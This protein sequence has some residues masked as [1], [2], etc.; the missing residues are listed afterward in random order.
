[1]QFGK[2]KTMNRV[3]A[4]AVLVVS[5]LV[6]LLTIEPTASFW[7]CGEF[8]LTSYNLEIGHPPGNPFFQLMGRLFSMFAAPEHAAMMVNVMSALCSSFTIFFLYL[9]IVHLGRRVYERNGKALD[10]PRSIAVIGAGA[11][12]SMAYCFSDTFWFSA[13][14]GEVYAMSSLFTALVFWAMLRWEEE[15]DSEYADRW[16][17]LI[18]LLMG[19]SIGVHLLNLLALPAIVFIYYYRK[20][21]PTLKKS[22]AALC[23]SALLVAV[24]LFG[25]IPMVPKVASWFDLLFVNVFGLPYNSGTVVFFLLLFA[26]S[27]FSVYWTYSEGKRVLNLV[28]MS[29]TMILFGFSVFAVVLIRSTADT[30]INENQ[31]DNPFSLSSYLARDQYGSTPLLFG[32]AYD[33][34]YS[35]TRDEYYTKLDGKYA[36]VPGPY[37][38]LYDS[39]A[40]MFFPRMWSSSP[41]HVSFYKYYTGGKGN[42]IA[43]TSNYMPKFSDNMAFFF[44]YQINWM[45]VRYF[46]WNF[47]G[48]QNDVHGPVPG[49]I[50]KGNWE[51][52]IGFIDRARLGDQSE[53]PSYLVDSK[54]KNHYYFL[55]F[56]LGLIG[57]FYQLTYDKR[58]WWVTMLLF[59]LT[60]LAIVL[61]L[62]QS[63][64]Q[65]RERDYAYAGSFY[66]FAIWIGLGV[67]ALYDFISSKAKSHGPA[68]ATA[69]AA[70]CFG[71]PVLMGCENWD[72]HD[73]SGR[74]TVKAMAANYL[75]SCG[76]DAILITYGDNDTFPLWYIQEVEGLR[77]DIR[78]VN[79][80]YL[81]TDWYI[82]QMRNRQNDSDPVK[83]S[84]SRKEYV[85]IVNSYVMIDDRIKEPVLLSEAMEIFRNPQVRVGFADGSYHKFLPFRKFIIPVNKENAIAAGLIREEDA[86]KVP[87]S[88]TLSIPEGKND[89]STQELFFLDFLSTYQWDR[90]VSMI[91]LGGDIN[92][93]WTDY[94]RFDGYVYTFVPVKGQTTN[95]SASNIDV[96]MMYD[97]LMNVYSYCFN[98]PDVNYDYQ[99]LSIFNGVASV[100]NS[101]AQVIA[102]M[103]EN[104]DNVRAMEL[105]DRMEQEFPQSTFPYYTSVIP[106]SNTYSVLSVIRARYA[107]GDDDKALDMARRLFDELYS[108][109]KLVLNS[110][111]DEVASYLLDENLGYTYALLE[112]LAGRKNAEGLVNDIKASW[113][114]V[115]GT[116]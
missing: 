36:S 31:P 68:M 16:I 23:I 60:G 2:F 81:Q 108:H 89:I 24:I 5:S 3:A 38:P 78:I 106:S 26:L 20:Y 98:D 11:V 6:Y 17:V 34:P 7:D 72:D 104:G 56:V 102:R 10:L 48:R 15:A 8:I 86:D 45:Y 37:K 49:D 14:E 69:V 82:E 71:V 33:S 101:F 94:M 112:I 100:R 13:V 27:V 50:Y 113:N 58:N 44:D 51:S 96:D 19:I 93:G 79:T 1:M 99:N 4:A 30:P 109:M 29:F 43:G 9:T 52:G 65:V 42:R 39:D 77:T 54:G 57:L 53:G 97:K 87:D 12:G 74:Y 110:S 115:L 88:I 64:Y 90:P 59:L 95:V 111:S 80:S 85:D 83:I 40:K 47:V 62:N 92:I 73:R 22:F 63:P 103:A 46:M 84:M 75:E 76:E 41:N 32:Q 35:L 66:A 21:T 70:V 116:V 105:A 61:Y 18:F 25:I 28:M 67:M 107:C 114:T 91:T 55:P